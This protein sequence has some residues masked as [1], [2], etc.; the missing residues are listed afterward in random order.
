M[1]IG[2]D[3]ISFSVIKLLQLHARVA[4]CLSK[5]DE[6]QLWSRKHE[7]SNSVANLCLHMA[8]NVRQWILHGV[9]AQQD[10]R[11]RDAEF[12]T[13]SGYT[14]KEIARHLRGTVEEACALI[15]ALPPERLA[16]T[17]TPQNYEVSVL[18][19]IYHVV[20]HFAQH[21]GQIIHI[22]KDQTGEDL[23]F[24]RHLKS[25]NPGPAP[26]EKP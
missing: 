12:E 24:Y 26:A 11:Q 20:E 22:T 16:E 2:E 19:A 3:F 5:L 4:V 1:S 18:E 15:R 10:M 23:G 17:V 9:F 7:N 25:A 21:T 14:R 6:E 13:R 8:G